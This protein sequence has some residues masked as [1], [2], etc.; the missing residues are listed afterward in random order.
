MSE[1]KKNKGMPHGRL[2]ERIHAKL[3]DAG[4]SLE[5]LCGG[6]LGDGQVRVVCVA[7]GLKESV[8]ELGRSLRDQVV[9]VR[10]DEE[11]CRKLD[12]WVETGVVKSRSEAAALFIR[13]G[14]KVRDEELRQLEDAL[15]EVEEAKKKLHERARNVFGKQDAKS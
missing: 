15:R 11:T 1:E 9:M 12:A 7:P 5:E 3:E 6:E 10:V 2:W 13:E 14:L 4:V 8:Q